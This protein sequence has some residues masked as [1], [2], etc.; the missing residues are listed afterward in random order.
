M[1]KDQNALMFLH[2]LGSFVVPL[3][4]EDSQAGKH[5]SYTHI[6]ILTGGMG[7]VSDLAF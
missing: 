4:R 3:I 1:Y 6:H 7:G 5:T 2:P